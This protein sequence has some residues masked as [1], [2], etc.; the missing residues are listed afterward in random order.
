MTAKTKRNLTAI[1]YIAI[2][3]IIVFIWGNSCVGKEQ[4]GQNSGF[5]V[6]LANK[7]FRPLLDRFGVT[8]SQ[9]SYFIRK[10]GHFSEFF[11]LGTLISLLFICIKKLTPHYI[12]HAFSIGLAVAVIDES[13][14]IL[15]GRGPMVQDVLLDFTAYAI[16]LIIVFGISILVANHKKHKQTEQK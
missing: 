7:M 16:A 3:C 8:N 15:S 2:V 5:F 13:I 10:L 1:L 12:I 11:A 9:L 4:S 6:E 14:Q